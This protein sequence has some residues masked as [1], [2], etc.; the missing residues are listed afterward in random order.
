MKYI[1]LD[2]TENDKEEIL[3]RREKIEE[4]AGEIIAG[5][6]DTTDEYEKVKYV[7]ETY[8][9]RV[10][11]SLMNQYTPLPHVAKWPEINRKVTAEEYEELVDY[12]IE[13]GVENGFIQEKET[14]KESFIPIW[15][16][17]GV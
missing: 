3:T 8:G 14:A 10:F 12:A 13:I 2:A 17:E 15:N 7:Y 4:A 11:L 6:P 1:I 5:V 9:D 16:G